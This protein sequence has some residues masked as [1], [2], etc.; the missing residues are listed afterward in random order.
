M[1]TTDRNQL[2]TFYREAWQKHRESRPMEPL[3]SQIVDVILMHPEYHDLLEG[4]QDNLSRDYHPEDGRENPFLHMG[5]HLALREQLA[6]G[7]PA[8]CRKIFDQ[9]LGINGDAH[10]TEH[11]M[12][13]C[14]A[15]A[16]YQAQR[17]GGMPDERAYTTCLRHLLIKK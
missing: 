11:A 17:Q 14:L 7:R 8:L 4:P 12:M 16:L 6:T 15:E 9:L 3:E 2:R 5:L 10:R 1:F 13:E